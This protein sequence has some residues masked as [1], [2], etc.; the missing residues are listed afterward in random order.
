MKWVMAFSYDDE[1]TGWLGERTPFKG[2]K[3]ALRW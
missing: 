1:E 3:L 2:L